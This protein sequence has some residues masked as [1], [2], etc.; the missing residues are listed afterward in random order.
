MEPIDERITAAQL[1]ALR[2]DPN[3]ARE[4]CTLLGVDVMPALLAERT[5]G[6][7]D[8]FIVTGDA[9]LAAQLI[10]AAMVRQQRGAK[11]PAGTSRPPGKSR[12]SV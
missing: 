8:R 11:A 10:H 12:R 9:T 7:V 5:R 3:A 6:D 2:A 4:I 1:M